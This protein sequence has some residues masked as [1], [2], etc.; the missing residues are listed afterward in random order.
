MVSLTPTPLPDGRGLYRWPLLRRLARGL[1]HDLARRGALRA[2][3]FATLRT[4]LAS[5]LLRLGHG[6][7]RLG[8]VPSSPPSSR[9]PC[10]RRALERNG[11]FLQRRRWR[12]ERLLRRTLPCHGLL[13]LGDVGAGGLLRLARPSSP[14]RRPSRPCW[15]AA[16]SVT[17]FSSPLSAALEMVAVRHFL[18]LFFLAMCPPRGR[19]ASV[20]T[21]GGQEA[22]PVTVGDH[23]DAIPARDRNTVRLRRSADRSELAVVAFLQRIEQVG[24]G[25]HLAVVLDL[26]VAR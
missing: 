18:L 15:R 16:P 13:R 3:F 25:V 9:R 17:A 21:T 11:G 23:R 14:W 22:F 19:L 1:L 7:L 20:R 4:A 24:G 6:L 12:S 5:R 10:S 8:D 2:A 26:L